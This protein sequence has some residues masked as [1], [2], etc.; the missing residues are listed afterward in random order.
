VCSQY[1]LCMATRTSYRLLVPL[2]SRFFLFFEPS[3]EYQSKRTFTEFQLWITAQSSGVQ[4]IST[5]YGN[6]HL[7]KTC[8]SPP[9]SRRPIFELPAEYQSTTTSTWFQRW[10]TAQSSSMQ[11]RSTPYGNQNFISTCHSPGRSR[12]LIFEY[13]SKY[14]SKRTSTE[15]QL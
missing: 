13:A 11:L 5:L 8:H 1:Q 14:R 10:I 12:R 3:S 7:A 4:S 9:R 15:L 6:Q 2:L